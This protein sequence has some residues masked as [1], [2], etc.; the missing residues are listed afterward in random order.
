MKKKIGLSL[1]ILCAAICLIIGITGCSFGEGNQ[2]NKPQENTLEFTELIDPETEEA[3]GY[4]VIGIGSVVDTDIVIPATFNNLPVLIIGAR[5]FK[6]VNLTSVTI[7]QGIVGIESYAFQGCKSLTSVV[8]PNSLTYIGSSSFEYCSSLTSVVLPD[9]LTNIGVSA[10]S[11][12]ALASITIPDNVTKIGDAA[13]SEC[14]NLSEI[15]LPDKY[16]D[17][18]S[19]AFKDTAYANDSS[20]WK[21]QALY[22]GNHLLRLEESFYGGGTKLNGVDYRYEIEEGTKYI[23]SEA[24]YDA[25]L[26]TI[27]LPD[28]VIAIGDDAFA[29]SWLETI[30]IP[31][32][33]TYIGETAFYACSFLTYA[34]IA[35]SVVE[36]GGGAFACCGE[37]INITLSNSIT[38]LPLSSH[39][40]NPVGFF[41]ECRKL[42]NINLPDSLREIG[43]RA[44]GMCM[45]LTEITIPD[46]VTE[47]GGGVFF[48]CFALRTVLLGNNI[49]TLATYD[50]SDG[51]AGFFS[52][53]E[54]LQTIYLPN[55]LV[56]IGEHAFIGCESLHSI[57]LPDGLVEIGERAFDGCTSLE[58][59]T[60]GNAV[61]TIG[62]DAFVRTAYYN[63]TT[64]WENGVLYIGKYL[65]DA[66]ETIG[67]RYTVKDGTLTIAR[68]AFSNCK[69]LVEI[70]IAESVC[71]INA[72]A[73]FLCDSLQRAIFRNA[74][75]WRT[76][77]TDYVESVTIDVTDYSI[78]ADHLKGRHH[79]VRD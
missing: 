26:T 36:I 38:S 47:I 1:L 79:I 7:P 20:N 72:D 19:S 29:M 42:R 32:N 43:D 6:G 52:G 49:K 31:N 69:N 41:E 13:F 58:E 50:G 18:D 2:P 68:F 24:F 53:C 65:I 10:F 8:L 9:S 63:N 67:D 76:Q 40:Y 4:A 74:L 77:G 55:S 5:A 66:E 56:G 15:N 71:S 11:K 12:S 48:N 35:N 73:F 46:T 21:N 16:L 22:I 39:P 60:I 70:T 57:N 23:T 51:S 78:A 44:F 34:T 28:S 33:V 75:G 54:S 64:N 37:L 3:F 62:W 25:N 45:S 61:T 14:S 59:I 17:F 30:T 27:V